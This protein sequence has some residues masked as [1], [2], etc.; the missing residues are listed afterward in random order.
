[1]CILAA[2]AAFTPILS[3]NSYS[4]GVAYQSGSSLQYAGNNYTRKQDVVGQA[5]TV[6]GVLPTDATKWTLEALFSTPIIEV[7][8]T[9]YWAPKFTTSFYP[10]TY[11]AGQ[12]SVVLNSDPAG[13]QFPRSTVINLVLQA[14]YLDRNSSDPA[15][16]LQS[17]QLF[18]NAPFG[19]HT[20]N[21][22]VATVA[23]GAISYDNA[24]NT[25]T[26]SL[27]DKISEMATIVTYPVGY[28]EHIPSAEIASGRLVTKISDNAAMTLNLQTLAKSSGAANKAQLTI[29]TISG[30]EYKKY[31]QQEFTIGANKYSSAIQEINLKLVKNLDLTS[32]TVVYSALPVAPAAYSFTTN[33]LPGAQVLYL[34]SVYTRLGNVPGTSNNVPTGPA[35]T[36]NGVFS[37]AR[38]TLADKAAADNALT[39][40]S[41]SDVRTEFGVTIAQNGAVLTNWSHI[42]IPNVAT[43]DA[44]AASYKS[45]T[46]FNAGDA[47]ISGFPISLFNVKYAGVWSAGILMVSSDQGG[48]MIA[49]PSNAAFSSSIV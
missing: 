25:A 8:N 28:Q 47:S 2:L 37:S 30:V 39:N 27:K 14:L 33:Y 6:M 38:V 7:T 43:P 26:I 18:E 36:N 40:S 24:A 3:P 17:A 20:V 23:S 49:I 21:S 9:T 5:N 42:A 19:S 12:R 4:S 32:P 44:M 1:V 29:S 41:Y 34:G 35:W 31:F 16:R 46:N 10:T 22:Q 15:A 13:V 45:S 11:V 48:R